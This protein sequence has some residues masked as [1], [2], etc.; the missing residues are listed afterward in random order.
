MPVECVGTSLN[1]WDTGV[2][3]EQEVT[4]MGVPNLAFEALFPRHV[5]D[6]H[7]TE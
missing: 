4:V 7:N 5:K 2:G 3:I 6:Y 1:Y